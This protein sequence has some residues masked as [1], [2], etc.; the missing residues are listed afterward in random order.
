MQPPS[1]AGE[2]TQ[3]VVDLLTTLQKERFSPLG[4]WR[5]I[6]RSWDMSYATAKNNPVLCRSWLYTTLLMGGLSVIILV[7]TDWYEGFA[8]ALKLLPGFLFCLVCQ[9]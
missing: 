2:Q 9:Q 1:T 4:W 8:L 5:F 6:V 7:L 3:F